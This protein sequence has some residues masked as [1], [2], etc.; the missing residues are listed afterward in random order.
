MAV[1]PTHDRFDT[2]LQHFQ[3]E[4]L[5][6]V[7]IRAQLQALYNIRH[8]SFSR[9]KDDRYFLIRDVRQ[10]VIATHLRQRDIQ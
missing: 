3:V 9:Q 10:N 5:C 7:V 1:Y 4:R 6:D 2:T 8:L